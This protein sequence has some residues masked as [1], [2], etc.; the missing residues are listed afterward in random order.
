MKHALFSTG[1]GV[2]VSVPRLW[3]TGARV[4]AGACSGL[5]PSMHEQR[6]AEECMTAKERQRLESRHSAYEQ[7]ADAASHFVQG[8]TKHGCEPRGSY[9]CIALHKHALQQFGKSGSR[10]S[11]VTQ[12]G[13]LLQHR[14]L[15]ARCIHKRDNRNSEQPAH[16]SQSLV[17]CHQE[18]KSTSYLCHLLTGV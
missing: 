6:V 7:R 8:R 14:A 9:T 16:L 10:T 5:Q 11:S 3:G 4:F 1:A 15:A 12:F 2:C 13:L 17:I 18:W